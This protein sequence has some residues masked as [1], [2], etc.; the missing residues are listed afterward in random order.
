MLMNYT[1]VICVINSVEYICLRN[2]AELISAAFVSHF[3]PSVRSE[4]LSGLRIGPDNSAADGWNG[5]FD[6]WPARESSSLHTQ[7]PDDQLNM[8]C[9]TK[10]PFHTLLNTRCSKDFGIMFASSSYSLP[11]A[12]PQ[13]SK[14]LGVKKKYSAVFY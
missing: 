9:A 7:H 6:N 4:I 3:Q 14:H 13:Q 1:R 5:W 8:A 10:Q 2:C 12:C 11:D